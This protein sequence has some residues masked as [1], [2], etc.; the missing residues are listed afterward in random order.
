MKKLRTFSP[1]QRPEAELLREILDKEGVPCLL[2][3]SQL[4]SALGEI[5]FP[6]CYLELWVIDDEIY[7]R[8]K[9]LLDG[10]LRNEEGGEP[11]VC[12]AC[13]ETLEGQFG[14]CWKC[15]RLRD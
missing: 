1:W 7:P 13:G 2:R 6:E 5:P 3:N 15:G 14:A 9:L 11:W 4:V 10:F 8:A 12:P